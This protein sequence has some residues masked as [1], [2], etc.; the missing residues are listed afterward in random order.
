MPTFSRVAPSVFVADLDRAQR[1]FIDVLGF[2]FECVD[3]PPVRAV[4][5]QKN[6]VL[7]LDLRPE[8]AGSC[9]IH[10]MVDDL[11]S[12]CEKLIT[13]ANKNGGLDNITVV[14]IRIEAA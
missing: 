8:K 7:H 9:V 4:V 12:V 2:S 14:A 1:F 13:T 10:M 6:A 5:T 11:D 3:E